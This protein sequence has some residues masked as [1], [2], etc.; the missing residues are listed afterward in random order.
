MKY[1]IYINVYYKLYITTL[2]LLICILVIYR[3]LIIRIL[4]IKL[5]IFYKYVCSNYHTYII[6]IMFYVW[7]HVLHIDTRICEYTHSSIRTNTHTHSRTRKV[8]GEVACWKRGR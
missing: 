1:M 3:G 6:Y 4:N 8:G 5:Y 7:G 2:F